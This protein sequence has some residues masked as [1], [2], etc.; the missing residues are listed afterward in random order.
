MKKVMMKNLGSLQGANTA[1]ALILY[2]HTHTHTHVI[3]A[4]N[5]LRHGANNPLCL[6]GGLNYV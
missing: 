6:N 5:F 2:T 1:I 4:K 3:I